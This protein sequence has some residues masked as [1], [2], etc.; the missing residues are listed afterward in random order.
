MLTSLLTKFGSSSGSGNPMDPLG[1]LLA[2]ATL[3]TK[4]VS[5]KTFKEHI[6]LPRT[7]TTEFTRIQL[8]RVNH[9]QQ[10]TYA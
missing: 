9:C 8:T 5:I 6:L 1:I 2:I 7:L 10:S 4:H 3:N